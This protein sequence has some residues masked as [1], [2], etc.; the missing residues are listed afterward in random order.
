MSSLTNRIILLLRSEATS[1]ALV[2]VIEEAQEEFAT[3]TEACEDAKAKVLDPFSTSAAV[4]LSRREVEDYT[5]QSSRL[6]AALKHLMDQLAKARHRE[7]EQVRLRLY[8][9]AKLER[10][11]LTDEF[12]KT[13]PELAA[14]IA[15]M[16]KRC[17]RR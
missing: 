13:Y 15:T 17:A 10:D 5:L 3:I 9:E 2:E 7:K 8:E 14:K 16:L 1:D 11:A 12:Q 6:E 4:A